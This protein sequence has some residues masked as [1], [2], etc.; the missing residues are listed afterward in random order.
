MPKLLE[1]FCVR[2]A[3]IRLLLLVH[4][5]SFVSTF[6]TDDLKHRVLPELLVG[7]KDTDDNLVSTTLRAL[8]DLV[9]IL[10]A[11]TVIGGN[12]AK[13]FTD[14]LPNKLPPRS[15]KKTHRVT[16]STPSKT[17]PDNGTGALLSGQEVPPPA[18]YL[19]ERPSPDGGEDRAEEA[20]PSF[21]EEENWSDWDG[22]ETDTTG[23]DKLDS[24][25]K[26]LEVDEEQVVV[27]EE[28]V[29]VPAAATALTLSTTTTTTRKYEKKPIVMSDI[30]EL[31][32]KNSKPMN[33]EP[34]AEEIDFFTD[35][36]PVIEKTQ[37][38]L[39]VE[40]DEVQK[41]AAGD[42]R[43]NV[44]LAPSTGMENE[45]DGWA[46]EEIDWGVESTAK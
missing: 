32:I 36:E 26:Q 23:A 24:V 42:N 35:M 38:V 29:L 11:A 31:D 20:S 45:D 7:I 12:R 16:F 13:L 8:A 5:N 43:F 10:G 15:H 39:H 40:E 18:L 17:P 22:H 6:Q 27:I 41:Q 19:A 46:D 1:M 28:E 44:N 34:A 2:D 14:G 25:T 30:T 4:L 3:S 9:P 33:D 37:P 21:A